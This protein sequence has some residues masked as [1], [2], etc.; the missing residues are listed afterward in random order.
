MAEARVTERLIADR[1]LLREQVGRGGMG[2]V[3]RADDQVL[4]R[5]VAVKEVHLQPGLTDDER[6]AVQRRVM[7]EARAAASLNHVGAVTVYDVVE[8]G[9]QAYIVMELIEAPTLADLIVERGALPTAEVTRIGVAVCD[10]LAVAHDRGIV[11]RDLKPANVMVTAD[12]VKLTDFGIA[13]VKD[14]PRLTS[15]G[16][17]LGSPSYISPEQ[18]RGTE[19][20]AA[21]D[22]WGL[23]ATLYYAAA[24]APPFDR[25]EAIATLTAVAHDELEVDPA[26]GTLGP[27]LAQMLSK[28]PATRPTIAAVRDALVDLAAG[29]AATAVIPLAAP[30]LAATAAMSPTASTAAMRTVAPPAPVR[31]EVVTRRGWI[32]PAAIAAVVALAAAGLL[33]AAPW[34]DDERGTPPTG[35]LGEASPSAGPGESAKPQ[36]SPSTSGG[37]AVDLPIIGDDDF[38]SYTDEDAG[39]TV[40]YPET[41]E[42]VE[43]SAT[44]TDFREPGTG[45]YLRV[46]WTD[47]PKGDPVKDW[48]RQSKAFGASHDN[49][50]EIRIE[51]TEFRD[52]DAAIWE[53]RYADGGAILRASNL[54]I[55]TGSRGYALNF[56]THDDNWA[57]S[58]ELFRQMR[59]SFTIDG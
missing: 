57:P 48:E 19:V 43:R 56:Q 59:D 30:A 7:R 23:G 34:E 13:T 29:G 32:G 9:E 28:D 41:W 42:R 50:Q 2:V 8:D 4:G 38:E 44:I 27:L 14:D 52:H 15:T 6:R 12:S 51:E 49:Y 10:V 36:A 54:A 24:G 55:V 33:V 39:Y 16:I 45:R 20:S 1:Y 53:Y 47:S 58:Q 17:V 40:R 37:L 11:H 21:T 18:A 5:T 26:T 25:G 31:R 22:V 3:W 46:D 35:V